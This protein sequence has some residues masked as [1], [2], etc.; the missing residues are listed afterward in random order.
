M[1]AKT[2]PATRYE[3]GPHGFQVEHENLVRLVFGER[4]TGPEAARILEIIYELGDRLGDLRM[5]VDLRQ[6]KDFDAGARSKM[7]RAE[8]RYP[9]R[10][11]ALFGGS[12]GSR[13]LITTMIRAGRLIFPRSFEF[14]FQFV[15]T[16]AEARAFLDAAASRPKSPPP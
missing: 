2:P 6:L 8:R 1:D 7:A 11:T 3:V 4:V 15:A 5:L 9:Y 16:E 10:A 12:F 14:E 13:M